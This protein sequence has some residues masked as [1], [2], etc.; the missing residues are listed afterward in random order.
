MKILITESQLNFIRRLPSIEEELNKVL[1]FVDPTEF[2]DFQDYISYV[3]RKTLTELPSYLIPFDGRGRKYPLRTEFRD[4][5][6][7]ELRGEIRK[8]YDSKKPGSLF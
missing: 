1:Q 8:I 4:Y 3:A 2:V 6:V 7:Y 5:I